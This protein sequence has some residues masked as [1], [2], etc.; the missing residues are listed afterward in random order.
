MSELKYDEYPKSCPPQS[1]KEISGDFYRLC[2]SCYPTTDDFLTHL[3][4]GLKFPSPKLCEAMT[5][6]FF[7]SE[8]H[9]KKMQRKF[10][11][12]KKK[13]IV[14]VTIKNHFGTGE[15]RNH[16]LNLW[17]YRTV[18]I[19]YEINKI[20]EEEEINKWVQID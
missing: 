8:E 20:K 19:L 4:A 5:L 16:H 6:S 12:L 15:V 17:E 10:P 7:D 14:K 18:S 11:N 13:S 9:A 3:D 2:D 1:A